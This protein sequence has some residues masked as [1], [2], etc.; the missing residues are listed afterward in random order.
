MRNVRVTKTRV[1]DT[2]VIENGFVVLF[3]LGGIAWMVFAYWQFK[4]IKRIVT[5]SKTQ[6]QIPEN[7]FWLKRV[8]MATE[9][10]SL[11]QTYRKK[12]NIA[13]ISFLIVF[14]CIAALMAFVANE[15]AG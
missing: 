9:A 14:V 3:A 15:V 12:R 2:S 13:G 6:H 7:V 10:D 1:M 11:C 8:R 5:V 4:F